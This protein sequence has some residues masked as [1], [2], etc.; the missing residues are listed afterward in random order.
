MKIKVDNILIYKDSQESMRYGTGVVMSVTSDEY[1][2][3]WSRRG[4]TRYKRSI[5]DGKLE[6]VF[7]EADKRT[8]LPRERHLQLGTSKVRVAFNENFDRAKV[9]VLCEKLKLSGARKSKDVAD[10]LGAELLTKK[11]LLRGAAKSILLQLAELCSA[12]GSASDEACDISRELF[13]GYVL[14]KSDFHEVERDK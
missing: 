5:L 13:F 11:L 14:Q 10:G 9:K 7:E 6:N 3:L 12:R 8:G 1:T 4:L 2:I